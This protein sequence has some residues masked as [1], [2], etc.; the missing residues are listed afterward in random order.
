MWEEV[1]AGVG[2]ASWMDRRTGRWVVIVALA[3]AVALV[4]VALI[5]RSSGAGWETGQVEARPGELPGG[6]SARQAFSAAQAAAQGWQEDARPA[7]VS[8]HW[9]RERGRWPTAVAWTFQFYSPATQKMAVVL[10]EGGQARLFREDRVPYPLLTFDEGRWRVDSPAALESWWGAGGSAFAARG[11]EM[12]LLA[13]LRASDGNRPVWTITGIIGD[14][15]W[16]V[17]LD[18]MTGEQVQE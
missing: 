5:L 12:D 13:Q 7:I 4:L 18:G 17:Q 3:L 6:V 8:A 10:V 15:V 14:Q 9:R 16:S 11:R 1:A 2:K